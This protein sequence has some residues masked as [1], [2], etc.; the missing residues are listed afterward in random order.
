VPG[1]AVYLYGLVKSVRR[2]LARGVPAGVPGAGRPR[3]I[4]AGRARW[5]VAADV[6][7]DLYSASKIER[8][9]R[10]L[11]W[12]ADC[13]VAH[14]GVVEHFAR[15]GT[16]LPMKLFTI[17]TS[18][19]RA[20]E[21]L[22][23]DRQ[24]IDRTLRRID[25]CTEWGVKVLAPAPPAAKQPGAPTARSGTAFLAAKKRVRDEAR[26]AAAQ[27]LETAGGVFP[28]LARFAKEARRKPPPDVAGS[29]LVLDAA[30]LVAARRRVRFKAEAARL[31]SRCARVGCEMVLT[32]PW[33][34]YNFV[35]ADGEPAR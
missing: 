32:G 3:L 27:A 5:L 24:R 28:A 17:F 23:R 11:N 4:P 12:V 34:P 18:E 13:A 6:P 8:G 2:P 22:S 15:R 20:L 10:D 7:L 21:H 31:A 35:Q 30:Y 33:P 19:A 25:G 16:M 29:R 26:A 14:E 1:D 9:L